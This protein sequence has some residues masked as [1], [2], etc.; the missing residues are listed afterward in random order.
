HRRAGRPRGAARARRGLLPAVP[1]AVR[2]RRGGHRAGGGAG[3]SRGRGR[4]AD[5]DRPHGA[6]WL[7]PTTGA[8]TGH[9]GAGAGHGA[10]RCSTRQQLVS[11]Q[12]C[13]YYSSVTPYRP[14]RRTLLRAAPLALATGMLAPTLAACTRASERLD[15]ESAAVPVVDLSDIDEV[16]EIA[17]LVADSGR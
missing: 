9:G 7:S 15:A 14:R 13:E 2:G 5:D 6:R 12:G 1:L 10:P 4:G 8:E 17:E 16:P 11:M 3:R